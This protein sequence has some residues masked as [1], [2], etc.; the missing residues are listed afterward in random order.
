MFRIGRKHASHSYP[1][2]RAAS[3]LPYAR[4]FA[5]GP[6][7][8]VTISVSP[9]IAI[10]W[11][12]IESGAPPSTQ[13]RITPRVTGIVQIR[14]VVEIKNGGVAPDIAALF[15]VING[16][17]LPVPFSAEF[18]VPPSGTASGSVMIPILTE[19]PFGAP[20][21]IGLPADV[22]IVVSSAGGGLVLSFKGSSLEIQ[23][24]QAAT[25]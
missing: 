22:K 23:E 2:S 20:L 15:V 24:V 18:V 3:S 16:L 10:P 17:T 19:T 13:V 4:N 8:P 21:P 11:A 14:G 6:G 9:G 25:G 5:A 1:T 12:A 7:T